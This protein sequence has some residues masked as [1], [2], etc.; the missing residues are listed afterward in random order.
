MSK[1]LDVESGERSLDPIMMYEN[2]ELRWSFVRKVY[3]IVTFQ[4]LLTIAAVSV[5][6]FV[7]PVANFF[8]ST[9]GIILYEVLF[10]V[11]LITLCPLLYYHQKHPLNYFLLLIFNI[12]LALP[13]GLTCDFAGGERILEVVILTTAMMFGFTLYTFWAAKRGHDFNF[14]GSFLFGSFSILL[15]FILIQILFPFGVPLRKLSHIF[16]C[17]VSVMFC[18]YIVYDTNYLIKTFTYDQHIKAFVFLYRDV[19]ISLFLPL[20]IICYFY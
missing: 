4:L 18:G 17:L 6:L 15:L 1:E 14:L 8:N 10:F 3:S 7:R 5:V 20:F 16:G 19:I 11:P 12:F 2:P 9:Q 13:V